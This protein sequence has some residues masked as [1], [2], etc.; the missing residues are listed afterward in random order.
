MIRR[1]ESTRVQAL[2]KGDA[3]IQ[4]EVLMKHRLLTIAS[5]ILAVAAVG[6]GAAAAAGQYGGHDHEMSA[7]KPG[8]GRHHESGKPSRP[9]VTASRLAWTAYL[10]GEAEVDADGDDA[11]DPDAKGTGTF[12]VV[13][14]R[15]VCWTFTV[16]GTDIPSLVHIH[17]GTA[18]AT[19][20]P[21]VTFATGAPK[22]EDGQPNGNPGASSG[23]KVAEGEEAAALVRIRRNMNRV[24]KGK[25]VSKYYVNIHTGEFPVGAV[26]GQLSPLWFNNQP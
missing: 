11:G 7:G 1:E 22:G 9:D 4:P 21:V 24:A 18:D 17:S 14:E 19:G 16:R 13:D 23:C 6:A 3:A 20:D 12:L 8:Y 26:R 10:N 5:S 15:T 2:F 25:A